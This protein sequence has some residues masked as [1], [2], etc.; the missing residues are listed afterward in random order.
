MNFH[1]WLV[2]D[3]SY[4]RPGNG[5]PLRPLP[6][7]VLSPHS[8]FGTSST[9]RGAHRLKA[10]ALGPAWLHSDLGST[11]AQSIALLS[12]LQTR[13]YISYISSLSPSFTL[14]ATTDFRFPGGAVP[15]PG[16]GPL[17]ML[18]VSKYL[19]FKLCCQFSL[20]TGNLIDT[21]SWQIHEK[22]K[23]QTETAGLTLLLHF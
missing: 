17:F 4:F 23:I 3:I 13:D 20:F 10:W 14:A 8:P 18:P 1:T 22:R 12:G 2:G 5:W 7:V 19:E 15:L 16:S 21:W 11:T 6:V 9:P